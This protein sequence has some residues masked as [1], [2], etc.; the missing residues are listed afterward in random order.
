M[1]KDAGSEP[2]CLSPERL[3]DLPGHTAGEQHSHGEFPSP[4]LCPDLSTL[5]SLIPGQGWGSPGTSAGPEVPILG[6]GAM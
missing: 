1:V 3:S 4:A 5:G 2:A 6:L